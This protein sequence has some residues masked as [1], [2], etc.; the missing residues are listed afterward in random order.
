MAD[1]G[2]TTS[3]ADGLQN[4]LLVATPTL[5][6]T[7]WENTVIYICAHGDDGAMGIVINRPLDDISFAE[8]T[9]ELEIPQSSRG[10]NPIIYSGGPV[11]ANRGFVLHGDGYNHET[12][13]HIAP[14]MNLSATSDIVGAI[15]QG[16]APTALNFC[17][18][19]A[20]WDGGQLEQ[21]LLENSWFSMPA[22]TDIIYKTPP[23]DRYAACLKK[24]G[25][26]PARMSA[27]AGHA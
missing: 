5:M 7:P 21:E 22:D 23:E 8:I 27:F 4:S 20:G 10:Q 25:L 2:K 26:D 24:M 11:E 16:T 19:Y 15:A 17:L 14:G 1:V 12:T 13:M 3:V 18:G 9:R 6:D